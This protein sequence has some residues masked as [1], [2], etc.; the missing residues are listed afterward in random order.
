M[1]STILHRSNVYSH[2]IFIAVFSAVTHHLVARYLMFLRRC[3]L[4]N[5]ASPT[6]SL[7]LLP[8]Y[9]IDSENLP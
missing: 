6:P 8:S 1:T 2:G 7:R 9:L 4:A 5:I 3:G